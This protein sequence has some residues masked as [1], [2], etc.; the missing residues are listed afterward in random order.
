MLDCAGSYIPCGITY[1]NRYLIGSMLDLEKS[2]SGDSDDDDEDDDDESDDDHRDEDK[3]A[4]SGGGRHSKSPEYIEAMRRKMASIKYQVRRDWERNGKKF[5]W[6]STPLLAA[7]QLV[8]G[9]ANHHLAK[10]YRFSTDDDYT[11]AGGRFLS[12]VS[13]SVSVTE[14]TCLTHPS[15]IKSKTYRDPSSKKKSKQGKH[16]RNADHVSSHTPSTSTS[17]QARQTGNNSMEMTDARSSMPPQPS[18]TS[19]HSAP[20]Y[21]TSSHQPPLTMS[22]AAALSRSSQ[23]TC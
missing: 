6:F 13:G 5:D 23:Y 12:S 15:V 7:L 9:T 11:N 18:M 20:H 21:D 8:K 2:K 3:S 16:G 1:A 10:R 17:S 14:E 4:G 19:P 22:H